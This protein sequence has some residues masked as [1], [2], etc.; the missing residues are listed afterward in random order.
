MAKA[1]H[2]DQRLDRA[3]EAAE[4][5]AGKLSIDALLE[6]GDSARPDDQ[7]VALLAAQDLDAAD[8]DRRRLLAMARSILRRGDPFPRW[9]ALILAGND[10]SEHPDD[11]W[12]FVEEFGDSDDDDLLAG[13]ACV[14]L[15]HLLEE[16]FEST[17]RRL[18]MLARSGRRRFGKT[19]DMCWSF[20]GDKEA[21]IR[22]LLRQFQI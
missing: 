21:G 22:E 13:V 12:P 5:L 14:L 7:A 4:A 18:E 19:I 17:R 20:D 15:E 1:E 11:V 9:Q 2:E 16:H 6:M 3:R 8:P 10:V